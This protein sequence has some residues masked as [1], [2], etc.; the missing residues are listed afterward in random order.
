M[1]N[2]IHLIENEIYLIKK[3]HKFVHPIEF[4]KTFSTSKV[5]PPCRHLLGHLLI[6]VDY[7]VL[8]VFPKK[9]KSLSDISVFLSRFKANSKL[10]IPRYQKDI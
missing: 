10:V 9:C 5:A 4:L 2:E 1:E 6:S 7:F 8:I 3:S